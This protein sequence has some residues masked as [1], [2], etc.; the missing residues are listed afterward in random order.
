M[1]RA[2]GRA[3]AAFAQAAIVLAPA[4]CGTPPPEIVPI[5]VRI[6]SADPRCRPTSVR[7]AR[8]SLE[9]DFAPSPTE[10]VELLA[11]SGLRDLEGVRRDVRVIRAEVDGD[12]SFR[13]IGTSRFDEARRLGAVAVLPPFVPCTL[14]DP[15]AMASEGAVLV[16]HPDGSGWV[17]GGNG[18]SRR[19][20]R[21]D[22]RRSF[23]DVHPDALFNPREGA[24]ATVHGR[25]VII[26]GGASGARDTAYDSYERLSGEAEPVAEG[27]GGRLSSPRRD[28][29]ALRRGSRLVLVGGRRGGADDALV[30]RID[31]IEL[32]QARASLGPALASPRTS[33]V[34]VPM[35]DGGIAVVGGLDALG[36]ALPSIER[37][38]PALDRARS[39]EIAVPPP[40][41]AIGLPL[42]RVFH[43]AGREVRLIDL[44]VEPA[45]VELL[46]RTTAI[47]R[48]RGL[49]TAS[50]RVLLVGAA[51]EG[52]LVAELWT[53]H[54]GTVDEIQ[55]GRDLR[56][57]LLLSDGIALEVDESGAS[58][59]SFEEPG[60]WSSL[61]NDRLYFPSDMGSS[62]VVASSPGDWDGARATRS[63][64][65]LA[66]ASIVLGVFA[67]EV[68]GTGARTLLLR[69]PEEG[70]V[71]TI[72]F[73]A[74]GNA[75]GPG[76]AMSRA[77]APVVI[78]RSAARLELTRGV[79]RARCDD[80]RGD[81]TFA[82]ELELERDARLSTLRM[83]R[84]AE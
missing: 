14:F 68:E 32:E 55:V 37:I 26:A 3:G 61:P 42:D 70:D 41:L 48:P 30:A 49:A 4:G 16:A 77:E 2:L 36:A 52:R 24:S 73:D 9:G 44:G 39:L 78:T 29:A 64:A 7:A 58:L 15:D 75:S 59:R 20:A 43:V 81:A 76:C 45:R 79:E 47:V 11:V 71:V 57:G 6:G 33:P 10:T 25:D 66:L 27:L 13:A 50:G 84:R 65:R 1:T 56:A 74:E 63:G 12:P 23:A 60:P 62:F 5:A 38:E 19:V 35:S 72:S 34:L 31:V 17:V 18:T 40:D 8:L 80:V 22:A 54:L 53:P 21:I 28:H 69:E 67:L 46:G 51:E 83:S 82:V